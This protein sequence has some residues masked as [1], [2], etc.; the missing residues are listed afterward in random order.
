MPTKKLGRTKCQ[1]LKKG[2][3]K[4]QPLVGIMSG[5]HFVRLAFCPHTFTEASNSES[6]LHVRD[7][8]SARLTEDSA[9]TVEAAEDLS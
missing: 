4:C 7:K 5:W 9:A 3:T 6:P 1:Q 2:R 8:S